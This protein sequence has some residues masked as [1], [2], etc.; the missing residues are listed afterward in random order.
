MS[1]KVFDENI[2]INKLLEHGFRRKTPDYK[3]FVLLGKHCRYVLKYGEKKTL[4]FIKS[5][6]EEQDLAFNFIKSKDK[7]KKAIREAFVNPIRSENTVIIYKK[8][9]E[10]IQEIKDWKIQK[11]LLSLLV[12]GKKNKIA[13]TKRYYVSVKNFS[14]VKRIAEVNLNIKALLNLRYAFYVKGYCDA[15]KDKIVILFVDETGE[16]AF[17]IP[18][19]NL[20]AKLYTDY[21]GGEIHYCSNCSV[22]MTKKSNGHR[23]CKKCSLEL[24]R[25]QIKKNVRKYREKNNL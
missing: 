13:T 5:F 4:N 7:I 16:Q 3:D 15:F 17:A 20:T 8:E 1:T 23:Y 22:R 2:E 18:D 14:H 11:I 25:E 19:I 21:C 24:R 9:I 10:R 6:S 12:F